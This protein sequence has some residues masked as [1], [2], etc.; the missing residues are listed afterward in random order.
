VGAL[1]IRTGVILTKDPTHLSRI[2]GIVG[3][4]SSGKSTLIAGLRGLGISAVHIAQEHSYVP[5]MWQRIVNPDILIYLDVTYRVSMKRRP[6]DMTE[7]DFTDQQNR[8]LHARQYTDLYLHTDNMSPQD[9]LT[10]VA[11]FLQERHR[12]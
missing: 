10:N 2:I 12:N 1:A 3:P 7:V 11:S 8:L 9:V 5:N 4:C 6:L